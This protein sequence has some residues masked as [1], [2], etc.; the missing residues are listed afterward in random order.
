MS[1]LTARSDDAKTSFRTRSGMSGRVRSGNH[2][3]VRE[4][5][6]V[7]LL[8][9]ERGTQLLEVGD[10]VVEG[11]RVG[12]TALPRAARVEEQQRARRPEPAEIPELR[13]ENPGP[14]G[15]QSSSGPSPR[16]SYWI[17]MRRA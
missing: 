1:S 14:P 13:P 12:G 4:A 6:Q 10:V 17:A 8:L 16:R 11:V 15:W 5:E 3:A 9:A 7:D 2:A